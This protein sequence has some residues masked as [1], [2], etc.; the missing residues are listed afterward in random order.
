[1]FVAGSVV[2]TDEKLAPGI[3]N[4]ETEPL[5]VAT[6]FTLDENVN[7]VVLGTEVTVA[8]TLKPPG[9]APDIVMLAPTTRLCADD[10]VTVAVLPFP[11][12]AEIAMDDG[13]ADVNVNVN[14]VWVAMADTYP[15]YPF[16]NVRP[17]PVV[18]EPGTSGPT[19]ET[20]VIAAVVAP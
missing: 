4:A 17:V 2:T 9:V 19:K 7:V 5:T 14:A 11:L 6:A 15:G 13:T 8:V 10:V 12:I 3:V 1:V 18:D 20:F 16:K